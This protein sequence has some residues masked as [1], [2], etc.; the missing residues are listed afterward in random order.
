[1]FILGYWESSV[2]FS[3]LKRMGS[4]EYNLWDPVQNENEGSFDKK[5]RRISR[6]Q[7]QSREQIRGSSEWPGHMSMTLVLA[8]A[9][10]RF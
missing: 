10:Q 5:L 7:Q 8:L 6:W 9:M 4:R 3:D 1:M 2:F